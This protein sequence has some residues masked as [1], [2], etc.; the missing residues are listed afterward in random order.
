[1]NN[2][3]RILV[4]DDEPQLTRVLRTGL[5]SHGFEVRSAADGLAGFEIGIL[6]S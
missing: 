2:R 4:V 5:T 3:P 1:M 6:T